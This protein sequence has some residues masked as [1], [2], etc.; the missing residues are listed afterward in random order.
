MDM[1]KYCEAIEIYE[2]NKEGYY[3]T[4]RYLE[5]I[6]CYI[7][8][9]KYDLAEA[10]LE[11]Y[12]EAEG[13]TAEELVAYYNMII[14]YQK[15]DNEAVL[16]NANKYLEYVPNSVKAKAYYASA[17]LENGDEEGASNMMADIDSIN[18]PLEDTSLLIAQS[19]LGR[20]D[21][22]KITYTF[23][24][25]NY[26]QTAKVLL[27]NCELRNLLE[28]PEFQEMEGISDE[29]KGNDNAS[30]DEKD[31]VNE[32]EQGINGQIIEANRLPIIIGISAGVIV[33]LGAIIMISKKI[34]K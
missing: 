14:G 32:V 16:L 28:D 19:I 11:K 26:P 10:E 9:G 12:A 5:I 22:A 17:L 18:Y 23:L 2:S 27:Y 33:L 6:A 21:D 31:V 8:D 34:K 4:D 7:L 15:H 24:K 1:G 20:I 29:P 25:E 3:G 13:Y 30:S